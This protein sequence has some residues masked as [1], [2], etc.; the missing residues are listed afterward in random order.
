VQIIDTLK[1]RHTKELKIT[2]NIRNTV[3]FV[4]LAYTYI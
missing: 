3:V 1:Y 2:I 4:S